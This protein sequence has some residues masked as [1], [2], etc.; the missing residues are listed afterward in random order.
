[1]SVITISREFG[2]K[3]SYIAERVAQMLGYPLVDK[4]TIEKVLVQYGFVEFDKAYDS[5]PGF[6]ALFDS[7]KAETVDMLNRVI[8][9][10][11][12]QGNAVI[13]GRGSFAV[14]RD[15]ADV[16]NVRIQAP[17]SL[18]VKRV[19]EQQNITEA[20][21]AEELVKE[22]D[23]VRVAFIKSYYG[24]RWDDA[25][26]FDV[27]L[28][29]GKVS[30]NLAVTWLVEMVKALNEGQ[31]SYKPTTNLILV[32]PILA[33]AVSVVLENQATHRNEPA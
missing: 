12:R 3:G 19:M 28:N 6:W 31:G 16:L 7:R 11:A 22:S 23:R 17:L 21:Q 2:S 18:R 33:N 5:I 13:L 4:G 14:L 20:D 9:A 24:L 1:M 29:T 8:R 27:V 10:V 30:P 32:D 26:V 15:L 25:S